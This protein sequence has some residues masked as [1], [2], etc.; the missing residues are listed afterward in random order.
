MPTAAAV[1]V[2]ALALLGKSERNTARI[3]LVDTVPIEASAQ[4]EAF[5]RE[6]DKTIY[7]VTSSPVFRAAL[8][9]Q[10]GVRRLHRSEETGQHHRPRGVARSSRRRRARRLSGAADD[11]AAARR[12]P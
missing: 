8:A 1:V 6:N 7:L 4:V 3:E 12:R 5:V 10:S 9:S 2:C 11:A